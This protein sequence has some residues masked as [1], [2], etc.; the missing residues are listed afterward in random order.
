MSTFQP[1]G[2]HTVTPRIMTPDVGGLVQF[3]K[4]VFDARGDRRVGAPTEI[5]I[6]DS[7][8][9]VSDGG[10]LRPTSQAFLYVYVEHADETYL[11][12]IELGAQG[13]EPP[14]DMPYGDRRAMIR[15]AWGNLWQ[16]ATH[17]G[18][19]KG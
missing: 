11:R 18:A 14:Q 1:E 15:D 8:I 16:I 10:G 12:A 4:S 9:L 6:G 5:T 2:R 7:T 13:I 17:L 3:L 19:T